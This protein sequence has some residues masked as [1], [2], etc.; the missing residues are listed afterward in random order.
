MTELR[1]VLLALGALIILAIYLFGRGEPQRLLT[2]VAKFFARKETKPA[3]VEPA[4]DRSERL[5]V[6][7]D[8]GEQAVASPDKDEPQAAGAPSDR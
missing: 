5:N 6:E 8:E 7:C 4:V 1:W 3:R 2:L